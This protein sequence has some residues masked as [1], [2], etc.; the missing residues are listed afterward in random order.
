MMA[1][2]LMG[3][4]TAFL[5]YKWLFDDIYEFGECLKFWLM[6]D[7]ISLLR[8]QWDKDWWA[9]LKLLVWLGMTILM[10]WGAYAQLSG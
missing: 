6:P 2:I 8:G 7:I 1:G 9:E 4:V 5:L 3:M 10:G